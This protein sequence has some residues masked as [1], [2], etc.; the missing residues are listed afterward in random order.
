MKR[1][2]I[3]LITVALI[4]G[5]VGCGG[6]ESYVLTIVSTEGGSVTAPGEGV[7]TYDGGTVVNLVAES[8]QGYRFVSWTGDVDTTANVDAATTTGT[9]NADCSIMANFEE[10]WT[11]PNP[12]VGEVIRGGIREEGYIWPSDLQDHDPFPLTI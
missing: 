8:E 5:M 12:N 4:A 6:G 3:F 7:F 10:G 2:S 9:I 11:F 1:V